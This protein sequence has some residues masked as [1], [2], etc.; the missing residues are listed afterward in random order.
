ML[1]RREHQA[2]FGACHLAGEDRKWWD[3]IVPFHQGRCHVPGRQHSP[4]TQPRRSRNAARPGDSRANT[5]GHGRKRLARLQELGHRM[6][7]A[8]DVKVAKAPSAATTT[9]MDTMSG[10][11][12]T[13]RWV[14]E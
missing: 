9:M 10:R 6:L 13:L 7:H 12:T 1:P 3:V 5:R 2:R 11:H 14:A 4:K 8:A